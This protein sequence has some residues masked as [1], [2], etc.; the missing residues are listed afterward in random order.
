MST[1]LL[2]RATSP[3][4]YNIV[5]HLKTVSILASGVVFF[6]ETINTKQ[7]AG[8]GLAL[9][10]I[11]AYTN[12]KMSARKQSKVAAAAAPAASK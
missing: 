1:Y 6:G 5:G 12:I 4:T 11:A 8:I 9:A 10:G 2:I 7:A 3:L